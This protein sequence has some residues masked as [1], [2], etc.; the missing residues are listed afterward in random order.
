LT[1]II[2]RRGATSFGEGN[3]RRCFEAIEHDQ[4]ERGNL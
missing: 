4:A 1:K 3:F 2:Q